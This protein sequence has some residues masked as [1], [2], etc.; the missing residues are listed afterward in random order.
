MENKN[1]AEE[2]KKLLDAAND[3]AVSKISN[4]THNTGN[5][6]EFY[7]KEFLKIAL[8]DSVKQYYQ[9]EIDELNKQNIKQWKI[10]QF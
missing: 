4:V 8:S 2:N 7:Q 6:I 5:R 9:S 3:Y 1:K 10:N